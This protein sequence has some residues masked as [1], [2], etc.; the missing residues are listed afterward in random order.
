MYMLMTDAER[1][2]K[3]TSKVIQTTKQHS[4]P[5][6]VTFLKKNELPRVG[7][8]PTTLYTLDRVLYQ[9]SYRCTCCSVCVVLFEIYLLR[10][11][12]VLY[13][14]VGKTFLGANL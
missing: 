8:K 3:E 2:R 10:V 12:V 13:M 7:F 11:H 1:R 9:P 14:N 6:A 4:T 5:K